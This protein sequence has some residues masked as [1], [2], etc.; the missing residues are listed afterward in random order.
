MKTLATYSIKGGVGKTSAAVNLALEAADDGYRTLLWDLDPQGAATFLLR[1]K[2]HLTD[3]GRA[4]LDGGVDITGELKGTDFEGLDL[5]PADFTNRHM[6][7]AFGDGGGPAT[8]LGELLEPFAD[9]YDLV[10]LDCAPSISFVSDNI[11]E[12]A[13]ALLVPMIPTTLSLRT[14]EQLVGF[15]AANVERRPRII[16]FFNMVDTSKRLHRETMAN[17][18]PHR[19]GVAFASIPSLADVENMGVHR[20]PVSDFAP[21]SEA[22]AS[23]ADLWDE[24]AERLGLTGGRY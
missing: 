22:A 11:F 2:P 13:D 17:L 21:Y 9:R 8:R 4:L 18:P 6:D 15:V 12:A 16:P 14:Y 5:L 19:Y 20:A 24:V 1:V 10:F 23:Y 3:G 7:L